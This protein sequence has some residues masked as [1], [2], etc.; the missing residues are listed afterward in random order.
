MLLVRTCSADGDTKSIS[1]STHRSLIIIQQ[2]IGLNESNIIL[3]VVY[4]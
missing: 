1:I 2:T 3:L 4:I